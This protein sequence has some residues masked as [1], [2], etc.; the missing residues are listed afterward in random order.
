MEQTHSVIRG[1]LECV[2][3]LTSNQYYVLVNVQLVISG[4][5][6][7][8]TVW[9]DASKPFFMYMEDFRAQCCF[10]ATIHALKEPQFSRASVK[11]CELIHCVSLQTA[12]D[13]A[14]DACL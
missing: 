7:H 1:L 5:T 10:F 11:K 3:A 8:T 14:K 12:L 2:R 4:R 6:I 9:F 13:I